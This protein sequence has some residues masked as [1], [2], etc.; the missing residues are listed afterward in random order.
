MNNICYSYSLNPREEH[1]QEAAKI[2]TAIT[3]VSTEEDF[4]RSAS[5]F[6]YC[7]LDCAGPMSWTPMTRAADEGNI[8]MVRYLAKKGRKKLFLLQ[9]HRGDTALHIAVL[10][11]NPLLVRTMIQLGSPLNIIDPDMPGCPTT[12]LRLALRCGDMAITV[13]LLRHGAS[14]MQSAC[15]LESDEKKKAAG[16]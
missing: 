11:K 8:R 10:Q 7:T 14:L 12:P 4:E 5:Q 15:D 9:N 13:L 3:R 6:P 16:S 2:N 1:Y